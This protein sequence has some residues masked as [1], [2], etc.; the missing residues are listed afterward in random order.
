MPMI[1]DIKEAKAE[2]A[3][4]LERV[5]QGEEVIIARDGAPVARWA[6]L[7]PKAVRRVPGSAKGKLVIGGDFEAP[8]SEDILE[9]FGQ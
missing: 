9:T 7:G 6:P 8:L 1:I 2:L 4:L 3:D 5:I